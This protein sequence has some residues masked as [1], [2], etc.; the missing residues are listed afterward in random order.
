MAT[1]IYVIRS[2]GG[3]LIVQSTQQVPEPTTLV[4][5]YARDGIVKTAARDGIVK[6]AARDGITQAR[7][8]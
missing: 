3:V 5:A 2:F 6:T 4:V 1:T 7:T 8:L